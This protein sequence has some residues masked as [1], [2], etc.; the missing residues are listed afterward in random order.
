MFDVVVKGNPRFCIIEVE[1]DDSNIISFWSHQG[2]R[3]IQ[4]DYVQLALADGK[5]EDFGLML[6]AKPISADPSSKID[7]LY[8]RDFI[9]RYY[10][11]FQRCP[12]LS[13]NIH[14]RNLATFCES[15]IF[16]DLVD[17]GGIRN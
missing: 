5:S 13:K 9:G 6:M 7:A 3:K 11:F 17:M 16:L 10:R 8:V 4:V 12:D 15:R 2:F 14:Y 1:K